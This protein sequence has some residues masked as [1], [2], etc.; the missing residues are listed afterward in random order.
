MKPAALALLCCPECRESLRLEADRVDNAQVESGWLICASCPTAYPIV[1]GVPRFV[2]TDRYA[3]RDRL[4]WD[5]FSHAFLDAD[6]G[7]EAERRLEIC[8]GWPAAEYR[9]QRLLDVGVGT[10]RFAAVAARHGAEVVG[11]DFNEAVEAAYRS[12]RDFPH[13]H[14]VQA[15]LFSLPFRDETFDLAYTMGVLQHTPRPLDVFSRVASAVKTSGGLAVSLRS[16]RGLVRHVAPLIRRVTTRLPLSAALAVTAM[17]IPFYYAWQIP[18][19]G[20]A[21]QALSGTAPHP[22]WRRRWLDT[23]EWSTATYEWSFPAA[24]IAGWFRANGFPSVEASADTTEIRGLKSPAPGP[25]PLQPRAPIDIRP[26]GP[27]QLLTPTRGAS[28]GRTSW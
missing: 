12:L 14:I 18:G 5:G 6:S 8:T 4:G 11:V 9:G 19:L 13:V 7:G 1:R 10:G 15:D 27:P 28:T 16:R 20:R 2:S 26:A 3:G 23:F 21:M 17:A 22:H 25:V 24:E